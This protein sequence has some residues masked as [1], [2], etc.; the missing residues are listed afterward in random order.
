ML[1]AGIPVDVAQSY[2]DLTKRLQGLPDTKQVLMVHKERF[3]R[4][5]GSTETK[6]FTMCKRLVTHHLQKHR[7]QLTSSNSSRSSDVRVQ[8]EN[9]LWVLMQHLWLLKNS[10]IYDVQGTAGDDMNVD[11]GEDMDEDMDI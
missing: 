5:P 7:R 9:H 2:H 11:M 6:K 4:F 3:C 8:N 10:W 1:A